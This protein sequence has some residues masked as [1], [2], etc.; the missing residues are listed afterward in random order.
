MVEITVPLEQVSLVS[1]RYEV[2][3]REFNF[4]K[5]PFM[6]GFILSYS[7]NFSADNKDDGIELIED[8]SKGLYNE[9]TDECIDFYIDDLVVVDNKLPVDVVNELK[10]H[11]LYSSVNREF[12][13]SNGFK[14]LITP[15]IEGMIYCYNA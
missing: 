13:V 15:S 9:L 12:S 1:S 7:F 11:A 3:P 14:L 8:F 5:V 4:K 10:K 6:G 2:K